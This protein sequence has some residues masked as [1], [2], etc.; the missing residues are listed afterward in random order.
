MTTQDPNAEELAE[1]LDGDSVEDELVR[2]NP[3][4]LILSLIHI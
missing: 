3:L 1:E 2:E 4:F